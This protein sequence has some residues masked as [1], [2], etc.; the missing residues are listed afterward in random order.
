MKLLGQITSKLLAFLMVL[1]LIVG[2]IIWVSDTVRFI[3]TDYKADKVMLS[4]AMILS[5][6]WFVNAT[7]KIVVKYIKLV[8]KAWKKSKN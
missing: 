2:S 3:F 1:L 4:Y 6:L 7:I 5:T 8:K